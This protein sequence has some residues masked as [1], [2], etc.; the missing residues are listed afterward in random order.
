MLPPPRRPEASWISEPP[1]V[2]TLILNRSKPVPGSALS[3]TLT[4][5]L[6]C[7]PS[8]SQSPLNSKGIEIIGYQVL[9]VRDKPLRVFSADLPATATKIRVPAEFLEAGVEYKVEVLAIEANRNQTLSEVT[10]SIS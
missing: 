8:R 10:F 6:H 9:V 1:S 3:S 4:V 2:N 7:E 5:Y